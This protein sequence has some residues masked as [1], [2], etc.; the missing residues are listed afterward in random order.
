MRTDTLSS[1]IQG[2]VTGE[3]KHHKA[4]WKV[5]RKA[6][7]LRP[8]MFR[9]NWQKSDYVTDRQSRLELGLAPQ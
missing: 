8:E 4:V 9:R 3:E 7:S 1:L 5:F 6:A 2:D